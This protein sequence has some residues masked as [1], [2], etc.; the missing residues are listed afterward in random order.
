MSCRP[1][2]YL[3]CRLGSSSSSSKELRFGRIKENFDQKTQSC[4]HRDCS[5]VIGDLDSS[6]EK[7][8]VQ[9]QLRSLK[10]RCAKLERKLQE[11]EAEIQSMQDQQQLRFSQL[12]H[13]TMRNLRFLETHQ[14]RPKASDW[15]L[16]HSVMSGMA[17]ERRDADVQIYEYEK[18]IAELYEEH[19]QEKRKHEVLVK[20]LRDHK[21]AKAKLVKAC[22][23]IKQELQAVKDSGL[24]QMLVDIEAKCDALE[25]E[26][27]QI[28]E[29]LLAERLLREK[30]EAE[31]SIITKKLEDMISQS[32]KW[33]GIVTR[34]NERLQQLRD[35][36]CE[37]QLTI[38]NLKADL[39]LG[40]RLP[41]HHHEENVKEITRLKHIIRVEKAAFDE[42]SKHISKVAAEN[43]IYRQQLATKNEN[44]LSRERGASW[45]AQD[46][47]DRMLFQVGLI[48]SKLSALT[49]VVKAYKTTNSMNI[50]ILNEG[51][52]FQESYPHGE[53]SRS[54]EECAMQLAEGVS[55]AA[56]CLSEL[57]DV[58]E[59]T[60][61]RLTGS[62]CVLQ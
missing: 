39:R 36:I 48:K 59:D 57:Q 45:A 27:A 26:N 30:L 44:V 38:D 16:S 2:C 53:N 12:M 54:C 15:P 23:H 47:L 25:K 7:R 50:G 14:C 37:H 4:C 62:S 31:Q 60:C 18:Q 20:C 41:N 29:K 40:D 51:N 61:A 56:C 8:N 46:T 3:F 1:N 35:Q 28:T 43:D 5:A 32:T 17:H 13:E 34:K 10:R 6:D 42:S 55:E 49:K 21:H 52:W 58:V 33:E 24:S 19:Q 22:K 11:K 9:E